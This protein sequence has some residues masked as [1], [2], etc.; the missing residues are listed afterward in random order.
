[1]FLI[2]ALYYKEFNPAEMEQFMS[3]YTINYDA[4]FASNCLE[5]NLDYRLS[6][7]IKNSN[8]MKILLGVR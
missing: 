7:K 1:M 2:A 5:A 3:K 4:K 6:G 8:A